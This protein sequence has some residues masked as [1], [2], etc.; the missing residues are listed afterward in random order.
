MFFTL[1]LLVNACSAKKV[2]MARY[3][4]YP[5]ASS[6]HKVPSN[7]SVRKQTVTVYPANLVTMAT[8]AMENAM[9]IAG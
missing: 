9:S 3:V 4:T 8:I 2:S 5:V 1:D 7:L 6:V